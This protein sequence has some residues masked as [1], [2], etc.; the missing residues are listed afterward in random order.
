[1]ITILYRN[2]ARKEEGMTEWLNGCM[3]KIKVWWLNGYMDV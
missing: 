3:K 2:E 1:M